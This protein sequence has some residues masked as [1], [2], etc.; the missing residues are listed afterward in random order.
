MLRH[1]KPHSLGIVRAALTRP[2]D[3]Q[4]SATTSNEHYSNDRSSQEKHADAAS[5]EISLRERINGNIIPGNEERSSN[6]P[7]AANA[8]ATV[9][10]VVDCNTEND[11]RRCTSTSKFE[12]SV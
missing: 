8:E 12:V 5:S 10:C 2:K 9:T 11:Y 4:G 7:Q 3:S 6:K 1:I